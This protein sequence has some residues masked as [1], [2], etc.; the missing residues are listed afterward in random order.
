M[1]LGM[2][3][4][5][6]LAPALANGGVAQD[7]DARKA[8]EVITAA[9][10]AKGGKERLLQ[11]PAWHIKY[12]ETFLRDGKNLVET[13]E[14]YEHLA[15]GQARYETGPD[16]FIVVNG[17]AGWVKKGARVTPLTAGQIADFQEYLKGKEALLTLLPLLTDDWQVAFLGEKE[18]D[19]KAA[20]VVKITHKQWTATTYWDKKTHLLVRAEYPHKRL[21]EPDDA[22]RT[23]TTRAA[24]FGDF[25]AF[26]G[27]QFH[28]K[29]I[30]Y[31][32]DKQLG[33]VTFTAV[34][35]LKQLPQSV[36]AAPK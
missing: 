36:I 8:R 28:T 22:R 18:V 27:I 23:A 10:A 13:G 34:E 35:P 32:G 25:R 15:R 16:D 6:L 21:T 17:S 19:G 4:P 14:T 20:S 31:A 9:V 12:R 30:A 33:E 26:A 11:L 24:Y 3:G 5:L 7:Q 29:L 1:L 2:I